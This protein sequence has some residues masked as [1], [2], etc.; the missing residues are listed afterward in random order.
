MK[1]VRT[2]LARGGHNGMMKKTLLLVLALVLQSCGDEDN[3]EPP[4]ELVDF[5]PS[6]IIEQQWSA[7]PNNGIAHYYLY[8]EPLV[9]EDHLVTAGREGT[10]ALLDI[11]EGDEVKTVELENV[12]LSAGV[13]GDRNTW[14]V[15]TNN[16][17]LIA[18]D[19]ASGKPKWQVATPSEVLST[20]VMTADAVIIR[21]VDGH[22][23]SYAADTG[24][25]NW[26]YSKVLP[27][28]TLRGIGKPVVTRE[29][30]I[31]GQE[32]GH[33]VALTLESGEVAWDVALSVAKGRSEIQRLVDIDGHSEL[34]GTVLYAVGFQGR[35]AAIDVTNG[36]FLWARS[37][38]SE[39]GVSVDNNAVYVTDERGHIWALD[40]YNGATL[41]KQD[42]LTAR[43]VTR[44]VIIGDYLMVGDYAG[45]LHV[46]SQ[47]D[48]AFIARDD[49]GSEGNGMLVPPAYTGEI[50]IVSLRNGDIYAFTVET[51]S[52]QKDSVHTQQRLAV[53]QH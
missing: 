36:Q 15:A 38:S 47:Q 24:E 25:L 40:R 49:I 8:L 30:V 20:P 12:T 28:L 3:S 37:F 17:E 51:L 16:G 18:I 53:S 19:A 32:N 6:A 4:A 2:S 13:G 23:Q 42:Q 52:S 1:L 31:V 50:A 48:G 22:I 14:V 21:T 35:I 43:E 33:L 44:P 34:Y 11:K 45:V 9:L 39:T 27:A 41:W 29:H 5:T 7:S 10:V 26:S 46:L